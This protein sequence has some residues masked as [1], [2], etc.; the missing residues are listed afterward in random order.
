VLSFLPGEEGA[1]QLVAD[2][3]STLRFLAISTTGTPDIVHYP[4]SGKLGVYERAL[5]GGGLRELFRR[6]DAV[7]YWTD[8]HP[9]SSPA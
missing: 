6:E 7:D 9:P 3:G 1:H 5:G 2:P 8:E 4:D